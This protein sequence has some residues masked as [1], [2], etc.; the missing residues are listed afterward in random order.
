MHY[1]YFTN[2]IRC[3]QNTLCSWL[4]TLQI[5]TLLSLPDQSGNM[6]MSCHWKQYKL[7]VLTFMI[8]LFYWV[9]LDGSRFHLCSKSME[10]IIYVIHIW[11][12]LSYYWLRKVLN[13]WIDI[14]RWGHNFWTILDLANSKVPK[15]TILEYIMY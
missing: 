1:V 14:G 12:W 10:Y 8:L 3:P 9:K 11:L 13:S 5:Y 15:P 6:V 2:G 4:H 7:L